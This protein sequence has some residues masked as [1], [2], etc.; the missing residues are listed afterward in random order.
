MAE[1]CQAV[2]KLNWPGQI[3]HRNLGSLPREPDG[4][5]CPTTVP[6]K[7]HDRHSAAAQLAVRRTF[8]K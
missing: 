2:G 8:E 1:P 7:S 3:G 4:G 5:R 6:T